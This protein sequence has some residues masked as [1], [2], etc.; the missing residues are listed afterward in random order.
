MQ[1]GDKDKIK[2]S[3]TN[4]KDI[5]LVCRTDMEPYDGKYARKI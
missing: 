3:K 2:L 5:P 4:L 1:S